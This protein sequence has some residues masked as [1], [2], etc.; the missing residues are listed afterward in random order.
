MF[1]LPTEEKRNRK[2]L[3]FRNAERDKNLFG[4]TQSPAV[5]N[6]FKKDICII[7]EL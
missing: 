2:F 5:F 3:R 6:K 1:S 7:K 4:L